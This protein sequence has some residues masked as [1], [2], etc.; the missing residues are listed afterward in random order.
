MYQTQ[1]LEQDK[2]LDFITAGN[3]IFTVK[4]KKT[5]IRFT[6]KVSCPKNQTKENASRLFVSLL[7]GANN[8]SDYRYFGFIVND[9]ADKTFVL[10]RR[11]NIEVPAPSVVAFTFVWNMLL[12]KQ[13]CLKL[14]IWHE[15]RCCRCGR[16]LT[17]PESISSGI[18]PECSSIRSE[19]NSNT[20]KTKS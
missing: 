1:E 20:F 18:G 17:V 8:E 4:S 15:G 2:A 12:N 5:G 13:T 9:L 6:F 10:S 16:K 11:A 19:Y 7:T 3:S 14:E